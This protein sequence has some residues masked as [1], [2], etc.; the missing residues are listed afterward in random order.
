ML[1]VAAGCGSKPS[2]EPEPN[3]IIAPEPNPAAT[4]KA[5]HEFDLAKHAIPSRPVSGSIGGSEAAPKAILEGDFLVFR[6]TKPGTEVVDREVLIKV[7]GG[8]NQSLP[9][10]KRTVGQET[11]ASPDVPEVLVSL[12]GNQFRGFPNGYAMTLELEPRKSAML[13]GKIYLSLPDEQKTFLAGTFVAAA[14]R[15][16]T[17]PP[18]VEDVPFINGSVTVFGAPPGAV[19]MTGYATTPVGMSSHGIAG[20]EIECDASKEVPTWK[21]FAFDAPRM[22]FLVAG[23]GKNVPCRFEHSRLTPGRY[24][25][26]AALKDGPAVWKWVDVKEKSTIQENLII[27]P[28][29]VGGL[30][31]TAP[32]G[33]LGKVQLAPADGPFKP[34]LDATLFELIALQMNLE[35]D[36]VQR[37]ALFKNLGPGRYEVRD[38]AS[39]LVRVIEVVAG[40]TVELDFDAK[41]LPAPPSPAPEPKPKG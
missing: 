11:P 5:V 6:Q 12:P 29:R 40:K 9:V 19:V 28:A 35:R 21:E 34:T 25:I 24:L 30:E 16:P 41:P 23:D 31:V 3:V 13:A 22:T 20:V 38:K 17:E 2:P 18:G 27:D 8:A 7:R 33:S 37:K 39:G 4:A 32:L 1:W 36:I 10:G 26:F 14:P 15:L